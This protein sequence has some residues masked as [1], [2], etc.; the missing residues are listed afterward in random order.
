MQND[1]HIVFVFL[2]STLN[3]DLDSDEHHITVLV[4]QVIRNLLHGEQ[5]LAV[6]L[7]VIESVLNSLVRHLLH[8]A[9]EDRLL[10]NVKHELQRLELVILNVLA[11]QVIH[12]QGPR[13]HLAEGVKRSNVVTSSNVPH[14]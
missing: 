3:L 9:N 13:L 4:N 11:P 12:Y 2:L 7:G 10:H 1:M 8:G 14:R 5:H 6:V